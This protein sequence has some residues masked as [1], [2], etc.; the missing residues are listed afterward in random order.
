MTVKLVTWSKV[1]KTCIRE[2]Y[3]P[4]VFVAVA[5]VVLSV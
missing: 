4:I 2:Q 3:L 5:T 1:S